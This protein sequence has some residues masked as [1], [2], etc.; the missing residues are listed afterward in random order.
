MQNVISFLG[1]TCQ[2]LLD[3]PRGAIWESARLHSRLRN[4]SATN[5]PLCVLPDRTAIYR[6]VSANIRLLPFS[7]QAP[8]PVILSHANVSFG[9]L[10]RCFSSPSVWSYR[11]HCSTSTAVSVTLQ[12][13]GTPLLIVDEIPK[14]W[15]ASTRKCIQNGFFHILACYQNAC[16][17][18][19]SCYGDCRSLWRP[20]LTSDDTDYLHLPLFDDN[21]SSETF[22][23]LFFMKLPCAI[24]S[25][26]FPFFAHNMAV[27]IISVRMRDV[28][29]KA[30]LSK[31]NFLIWF[32]VHKKLS[33]P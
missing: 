17:T 24:D 33:D 9:R 10:R 2:M 31:R 15:R 25:Q 32:I 12:M 29:S 1:F 30:R 23:Y 20:S 13:F 27:L 26:L 19:N 14:M 16:L 11:K 5:S 3:I 21:I 8:K 22:W 6:S 28:A 7:K 4:R 18:Y